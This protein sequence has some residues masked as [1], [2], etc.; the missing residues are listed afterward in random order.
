MRKIQ[1]PT[2]FRCEGCNV[3]LHSRRHGK[4]VTW[5]RKEEEKRRRRRVKRETGR[6][7]AVGALS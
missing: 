3:Q 7:F 6:R 5:A 2:H 1:G 4:I